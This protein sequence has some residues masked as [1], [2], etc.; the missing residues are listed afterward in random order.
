MH[1]IQGP[2]LGEM[3]QSGNM[4]H[5]LDYESQ[6]TKCNCLVSLAPNTWQ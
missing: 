5:W 6:N 2:S 3:H 1:H 4:N